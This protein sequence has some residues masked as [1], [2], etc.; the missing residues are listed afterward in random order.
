V[1]QEDARIIES[2]L[3]G[4]SDAF[5]LLIDKYGD[6]LYKYV[7]VLL[8]PGDSQTEDICQETLIASFSGLGTLANRDNFKGWLFGIATNKVHTAF[9]NRGRARAAGEG[10]AAQADDTVGDPAAVEAAEHAQ[11]MIARGLH[12]L[13][14]EMREVI[15]LKY[16]GN[17]SYDDMAAALG[18]PRST[19]RGRMYRAYQILRE[20]LQKDGT[21][22]M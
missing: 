21:R 1:S 16:F 5:G 18:V 6:L 15:A 14:D 12:A 2:V 10:L 8:G 17:L 22:G 7:V 13:P 9:R 4:K 11:V 20:T 19:V 3:G